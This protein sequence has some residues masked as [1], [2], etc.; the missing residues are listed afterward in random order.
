[1]RDYVVV[2]AFTKEPF[3][4]NPAGVVVLDGPGDE[5][6]MQS[7]AAELN[8]SE[9]AFLHR[10][11]GRGWSLR[12]FTPLHEVPLCG[13]ATLGSAHAL[14]SEGHDSGDE[15]RFQTASGELIAR[16]R[17]EQI[18]L[19]F[20]SL[21]ADPF[22]P[23]AELAQILGG[24]SW[25]WIGKTRDRETRYG[26]ILVELENQTAVQNLQPDLVA[27]AKLP[28][29]GMI[30]T[31]AAEIHGFDMVSRYFAP[32]YGIPEDP[33]TGSAHCTVGPYWAERLGK[34]ELRGRQ[35]SRRTGDIGVRVTPDRIYLTGDAITVA[36]GEIV[37]PS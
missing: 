34:T 9:T 13:H 25:R 29:G 2:D 19:D 10:L 16:K 30:V 3:K 1:M 12:W 17:G 36:R 18:E 23:P 32:A 4:G 35:L 7:V 27:L 5:G 20:P 21:P 33:V 22:D 8:L 28:F 11:D 24:A 26:N 37:D 14:W 31:A 6:W 15:L